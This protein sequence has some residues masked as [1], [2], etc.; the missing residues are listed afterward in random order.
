MSQV[1]KLIREEDRRKFLAENVPE[2]HR[3]A[4]TRLAYPCLPRMILELKTK[5]ER[6]ERID[7]IP[8]P[9]Y[10]EWVRTMVVLLWKRR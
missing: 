4:I 10:R 5:E 6:R 3:E 7:E 1:G 8:D 2:G 9:M